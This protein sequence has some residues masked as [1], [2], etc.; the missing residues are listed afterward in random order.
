MF[1]AYNQVVKRSGCLTVAPLLVY[2]E[3]KFK[4]KSQPQHHCASTAFVIQ[5]KRPTAAA[6]GLPLWLYWQKNG[7]ICW[8]PNGSVGQ[9]INPAALIENIQIKFDVLVDLIQVAE[10]SNSYITEKVLPVIWHMLCHYSL[11]MI[12]FNVTVAM[13]FRSKKTK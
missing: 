13:I 6:A 5:S 2:P 10:I 9:L 12:F 1:A 11:Y 4:R 8:W 3:G 7:A